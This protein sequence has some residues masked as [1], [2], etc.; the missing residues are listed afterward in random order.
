M[1]YTL[2]HPILALLVATLTASASRASA[3]LY[4]VERK[5]SELT[6]L[7][8]QAI[9]LEARE[10]RSDFNQDGKFD[11]ADLVRYARFDSFV[12]RLNA[13]GPNF[14]DSDGIVW[15]DDTPYVNVAGTGNSPQPIAGTALDTLYQSERFDSGGAEPMT[16]RLPVGAGD[17][18]VHLHFAEVFFTQPGE[19]VFDVLLEGVPVLRNF[20]IV[21][22]AGAA[23]AIVKSF[24]M[25]T[26]DSEV[27]IR[28]E[29]RVGAPKVSAIEVERIAPFN[30]T[31]T[32][33]SAFHSWGNVP[34]GSFG[35]AYTLGVANS[36]G[37]PM[38]ITGFRLSAQ[39]GVNDAFYITVGNE[40]IQ[41]F[42]T[43]VFL[44]APIRIATGAGVPVTL[45]FAPTAGI[46]YETI[47]ELTGNF[48]SPTVRLRGQESGAF[49]NRWYGAAGMPVALGEVAAGIIGN[50]MY[51]AG[52]TNSATTRFDL[53]TGLWSPASA[54]PERPHAGNHHASEVIDGKWY[55]FGG[56]AAQSEGKTQIFDPA[57]NSWSLGASAPFASGSGSTA[58]I[59]G[60]VYYSGGIVNGSSTTNQHAR[61]NPRT[62]S[63]ERKS[64]M[65]R[66][67]NHA[68]SGTDGRFYY[69]FGGRGPGS[70][71]A[72]VVANGFGDVQIYDPFADSWRTS[73]ES[74]IQPLPNGRGGTGKAAYAYG[75]FFVFGGETANGGGAVGGNVFNRVDVYNPV[76]N[77][78]RLGAP[79]PT[80]RHGA[81]PIF[82]IDRIYVAGGGTNAGF[83]NSA[84]N[85]IY[86]P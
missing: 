41:G 85:D 28:F 30:T 56:L 60:F 82:H 66:G 46:P 43:E 68:A 9:A 65:P 86:V 37:E 48:V 33:S 61:Y 78:W 51:V 19:R 1:K 45:Y 14:T 5:D 11:A 81:F 70:G 69:V 2:A 12:F 8:R 39:R 13:G 72:N 4:G 34:F 6:F 67:R 59:D 64:P 84:V 35:E 3:P 25:R 47:L 17:Y 42:G 24:D 62:N 32:L 21:T 38:L 29:G 53:T 77:T 16:Y 40:L 31:V 74:A 71:D 80:P 76:T 22:E 27:T 36:G 52:E 26:L 83:S 50:F 57:S 18:R 23:T 54:L 55:L 75:E 49:A 79:M 73:M 63:W 44:P 10:A 20:D 58:Y 7:A 15:I